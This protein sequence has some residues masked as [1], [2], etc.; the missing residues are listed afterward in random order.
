M[1]KIRNLAKLKID[2]KFDLAK[3]EGKID[4]FNEHLLFIEDLIGS[5][6]KSMA[7]VFVWILPKLEG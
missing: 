1:R 2:I 3:H 7:F 5:L 6:Q 4:S